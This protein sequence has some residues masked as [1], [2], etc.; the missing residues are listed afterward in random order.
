MGTVW[1]LSPTDWD[2]YVSR[3]VQ[4]AMKSLASTVSDNLMD[5]TWGSMKNAWTRLPA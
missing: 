3:D 4:E 5:A 1:A 2:K